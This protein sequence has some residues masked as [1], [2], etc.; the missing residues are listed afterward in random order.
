MMSLSG[1][2]KHI[3]EPLRE[4]VR[5]ERFWAYRL[6][7]LM[8]NLN[9]IL[10]FDKMSMSPSIYYPYNI[11]YFIPI[12]YG[13]WT[14]IPLKIKGK[15][16]RFLEPLKTVLKSTAMCFWI[17]QKN[18]WRNANFSHK[19]E[20]MSAAVLPEVVGPVLSHACCKQFPEL[21]VPVSAL[22]LIPR[23]TMNK[24]CDLVPFCHS[25]FGEV[26]PHR[27]APGAFRNMQTEGCGWVQSVFKEHNLEGI[28]FCFC[29][30]LCLLAV[31]FFFFPIF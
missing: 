19:T 10:L 1:V 26:S 6:I 4:L 2:W 14:A 3:C 17:T 9:H 30:I 25:H 24:W 13:Q 15:K 18:K 23:L 27:C 31:F 11:F 16:K 28:F 5:P 7:L 12:K 8:E 22:I 21:W 29:F 20:N